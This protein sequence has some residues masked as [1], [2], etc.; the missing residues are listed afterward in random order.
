MNKSILITGGGRS[1]GAATA[2]LAANKGYRVFVN[3]IK[4]EEAATQVANTIH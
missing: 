1:I 4:N 3:Y 2:I